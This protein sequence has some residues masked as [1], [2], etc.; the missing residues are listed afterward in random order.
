[1]ISNSLNILSISSYNHIIFS[2]VVMC[3]C[4][5]VREREKKGGEKG[6]PGCYG[7]VAGSGVEAELS[8]LESRFSFCREVWLTLLCKQPDPPV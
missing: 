3:W 6:D 7:G 1:M 4:R 8:R 5:E 2:G